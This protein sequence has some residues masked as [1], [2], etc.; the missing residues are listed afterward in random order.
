MGNRKA[1][2]VLS[3]TQTA[4]GYVI[5]DELWPSLQAEVLHIS[6]EDDGLA[7]ILQ[8]A[9]DSAPM[10]T[11]M[12]TCYTNSGDWIGDQETAKELCEVRGIA[13][14]HIEKR[15]PGILVPCSIG[16]SGKENKWYGW[17]HRAI[18]GFGI[19]SE[20]ARGDVA[21]VPKDWDDLR[22]VA[23]DFWHD[24]FHVETEGKR[25]R[26]SSGRECIEVTWTYNHNTPNRKIRGTKG[27]S[28]FY[29]PKKWGKGEWRA[30]TLDDAKQMAKDFAIGVA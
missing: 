9:I 30:E 13:P 1:I 24:E 7:D 22:R 26:D 19:G 8:G 21:Y 28:Y 14:E 2:Q 4:F 29:P 6:G 3:E 11:R 20:V 23:V 25:G 17:S 5:R 12:T 27:G 15:E 18:C 10:A 16:L